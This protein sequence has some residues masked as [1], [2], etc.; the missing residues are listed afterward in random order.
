[1]FKTESKSKKE[2]SK[3]VIQTETNGANHKSNW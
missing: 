2:K 1:M 3:N